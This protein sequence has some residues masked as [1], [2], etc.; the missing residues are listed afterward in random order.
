MAN[1]KVNKEKKLTARQKRF[2]DEY[3]ID[4]N[5]TQAAIRA[6]YSQRTA[7]EQGSR[8]LT[9]LNINS[10]IQKRK[11]NLDKRLEDKY[12]ISKERLLQEY[13][14][15]GFSDIREFYNQ[16]G[17]LRAMHELTDDQAASLAGV[18]TLEEFIYVDGEKIPA[19]YTKKIKIYDKLRALEGIRKVM[20]YDAPVKQD[21]TT[22]GES[23]NKGFA[24]FLKSVNTIND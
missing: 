6:G 14:R 5:A 16:D 1:A 7:M 13:A 15:L 10:Y 21:H 23:L 2:C 18:E 20:G 19:G 3:L 12:L 22:K 9:N 11:D 8:L 24:D 17:G 4:L